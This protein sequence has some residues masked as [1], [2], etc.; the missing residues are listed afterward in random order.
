MKVRSHKNHLTLFNNDTE[1]NEQKTKA[2]AVNKHK[3]MAF[4]ERLLEVSHKF[5]LGPFNFSQKHPCLSSGPWSRKKFPFH[6]GT[7][8]ENLPH[9]YKGNQINALRYKPSQVIYWMEKKSAKIRQYCTE[10][11]MD[12]IVAIKF[13]P[14]I[15][16]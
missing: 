5:T 11:K 10:E 1:I 9:C 14:G 7:Q 3:G 8:A 16:K 13:K 2:T 6:P 15:S 4:S 12:Q